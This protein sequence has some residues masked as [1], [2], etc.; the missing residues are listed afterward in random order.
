MMV[1]VEEEEGSDGYGKLKRELSPQN[2]SRRRFSPPPVTAPT[3]S[4]RQIGL[5]LRYVDPLVGIYL[6]TVGDRRWRL[7][8]PVS[9]QIRRR[10]DPA[11]NGPDLLDLVDLGW[12]VG[13]GGF[14]AAAAFARWSELMVFLSSTLGDP[15]HCIIKE[16]G[17]TIRMVSTPL[18]RGRHDLV[19]DDG[20]HSTPL[21]RGR[22]DLVVD[23][24]NS[25]PLRET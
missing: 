23:G 16:I 25:T 14:T 11:I 4:Y 15:L 10:V 17:S 24:V 5:D 21:H 18:H 13:G 2:P 22:H 3:E 20:V 19:V 6:S 12:P 1:E 7:R 9:V 8:T